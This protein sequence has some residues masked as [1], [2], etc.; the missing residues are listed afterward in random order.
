MI[1]FKHSIELYDQV[2]RHFDKIGIQIRV[3]KSHDADVMFRLCGDHYE[4]FD[5]LGHRYA[6]VISNPSYKSFMAI[7][8]ENKIV[9]FSFI[10]HV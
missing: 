7:D 8:K 2:E 5:S 9:R 1:F 4:G 10:L 6:E 3:G